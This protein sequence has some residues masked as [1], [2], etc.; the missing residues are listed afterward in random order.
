MITMKK[1]KGFTLVEL[2][3]A[4]VVVAILTA[5]AFPM[6]RAYIV[7]SACDTGKSGLMAVDALVNQH[8]LTYGIYNNEKVANNALGITEIPDQGTP[9][10]D[11][12]ISN[13]TATTYTI[14]IT[15]KATGTL[16]DK[17]GDMSI[18]EKGERSGAGSFAKVWTE[19]CSSI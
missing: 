4:L 3:I 18:N 17:T 12:V 11:L 13:L 9:F 2:M 7:R 10:F 5:I 16:S 19:G 8:Y 6:Y 14:K 15:P 1:S